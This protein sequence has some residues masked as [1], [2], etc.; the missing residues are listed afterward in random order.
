ML[1]IRKRFYGCETLLVLTATVWAL[2]L[3]VHAQESQ[4]HSPSSTESI[5]ANKAEHLQQT[6]SDLQAEVAM[7]K[8]Q[9][10]EMQAAM[11]VAKDPSPGGPTPELTHSTVDLQPGGTGAV[12]ASEPSQAPQSSFAASTADKAAVSPEDRG[13]L[14]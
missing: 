11:A 13:I 9:M 7:L 1:S 3:N 4:A 14:D 5:P 10:K 8:E 12:L 6:V 2:T